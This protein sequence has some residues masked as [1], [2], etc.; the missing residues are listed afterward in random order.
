MS[1]SS[2]SARRTRQRGGSGFLDHM[3][4]VGS[5]PSVMYVPPMAKTLPLSKR[6]DCWPA[7]KSRGVAWRHASVSGLSMGHSRYAYPPPWLACSVHATVASLPAVHD[8]EHERRRAAHPPRRAASAQVSVHLR[9]QR[10]ERLA[11][12][13]GRGAG[14]GVGGEC[15]QPRGQFACR[16]PGAEVATVT[17]EDGEAA[18]RVG[19]LRHRGEVHH[20]A[21]PRGTTVQIAGRRR[22][23]LMPALH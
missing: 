15:V 2:R 13:A 1:W 17:V 3:D 22:A 4:P 21:L 20:V 14:D 8:D 23:Y 6:S 5:V 11:E 12:R 19:R 10:S 18:H 7:T 9:Q 16:P